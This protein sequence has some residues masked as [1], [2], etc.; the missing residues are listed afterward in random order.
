MFAGATVSE[1]IDRGAQIA[2]L[3]E[4][5]RPEI[6]TV[7]LAIVNG[8]LRPEFQGLVHVPTIA[9]PDHR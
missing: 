3:R 6:C 9:K 1:V 4:R 5:I 7:C 8:R 2:E